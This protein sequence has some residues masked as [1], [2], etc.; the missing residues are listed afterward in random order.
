MHFRCIDCLLPKQSEL[1]HICSK[2]GVKITA[3][4]KRRI[5][6]YC[7]IFLGWKRRVQCISAR[8]LSVRHS[9]NTKHGQLLFGANNIPLPIHLETQQTK[10]GLETNHTT[11]GM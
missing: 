4:A 5:S 1:N 11:F 10:P 2:H 8:H 7:R 6:T 9:R 3:A